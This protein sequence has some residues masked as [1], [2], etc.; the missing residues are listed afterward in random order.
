MAA[1]AAALIFADKS[2]QAQEA[3]TIN[4]FWW[5]EQDA[6]AKY[7]YVVG[8]VD[9][10]TQA[11]A[12][13]PAIQQ[14][15]KMKQ[16]PELQGLLEANFDY[17]NIAFGQFVDGMNKFYDDF[18]NMRINVRDA[19]NYVKNEVKGVDPAKQETTLLLL[20]KWAAKEN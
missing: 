13:M 14:E 2:A 7:G 3:V 6:L 11:F 20:R 16:T 8:Y 12:V 18:R 5:K 9:A 19:M 15:A 10:T 4:G 17:N 1:G